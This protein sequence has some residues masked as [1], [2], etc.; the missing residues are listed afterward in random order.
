MSCGCSRRSSGSSSSAGGR[1][2]AAAEA[3]D[4]VGTVGTVVVDDTAGVA[5]A[6]RTDGVEERWSGLHL[7]AA[8]AVAAAVGESSFAAGWT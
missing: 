5:A 4:G 2:E 6:G 7:D 8:D 1:A 3:V